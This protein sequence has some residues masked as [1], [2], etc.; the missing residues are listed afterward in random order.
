VRHGEFTIFGT[1]Y[2]S[3]DGTCVRDYVHV[4]EICDALSSAIEK[5]TNQIEC[6][7]HG[8]GTSVRDIVNLYKKVK[9]Y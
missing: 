6:S 7:D 5:S 2:G 8:V 3:Y 9:Q 4:N 1:D